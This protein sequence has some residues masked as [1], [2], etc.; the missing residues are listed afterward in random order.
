MSATSGN[1]FTGSYLMPTLDHA[2]VTDAMHPGVLSCDAEATATEVARLMASNHVHCVAVTGLA[3][4]AAAASPVWG[5]IEDLDLVRAGM[6]PGEEQTANA[7]ARHAITVAPSM[8]LREAANMMLGQNATH[9]LVVDPRTQRP[10]GVLSTLDIVGV[11][12]WG[13]S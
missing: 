3:Q 2:T 1:Q 6:R 9:A 12:A 8:A 11:L 13:E 10:T 4:D 5:I 7:F